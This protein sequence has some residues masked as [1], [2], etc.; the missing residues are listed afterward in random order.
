MSR[1]VSMITLALILFVTPFVTPAPSAEPEE[2]IRAVFGRFVAAQN[3][4][5]LGAT[6]DLLWDS[7]RFLW[8]TR[9]VPVWGR[10]AALKRFEA[11]YQG[12]W[13][14][15]PSLAEL[16]VTMLSNSAG[17]LYVPILFTSG[18]AGQP[19]Q[20]TH[21]LM[22][23]TIVRTPAGWK[24]ANIVPVP[25]LVQAASARPPIVAIDKRP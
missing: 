22:N 5:D 7:T 15:E 6:R 19:V 21:V 10:E 14:L 20:S 4:H 8:I 11:V 16:H 24:V 18:P 1:R 9:G 3:A 13:R 12:T 25:I 17:Q 2:E 23:Q